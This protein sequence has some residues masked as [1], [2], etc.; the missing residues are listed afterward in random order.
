MKTTR[1]HLKIILKASAHAGR[2]QKASSILGVLGST[3][4]TVLRALSKTVRM[5]KQCRHVMIIK[6]V[7]LSHA[8][9]P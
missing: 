2:P 6:F 4:A 8:A 5:F 9:V 1:I 3:S 7:E